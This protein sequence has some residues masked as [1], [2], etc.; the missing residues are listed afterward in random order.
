ML[1]SSNITRVSSGGAMGDG[2]NRS[3]KSWIINGVAA[4]MSVGAVIDSEDVGGFS[5]IPVTSVTD[6]CPAST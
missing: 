6:T 5:L 1:G 3:S 4:A 2:E